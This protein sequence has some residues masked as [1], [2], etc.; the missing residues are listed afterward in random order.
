MPQET[1]TDKQRLAR[2]VF[3][4]VPKGHPD[5]TQGL[6]QRGY[7]GN[8]VRKDRFVAPGCSAR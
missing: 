1:P 8:V 6:G 4:F 3:F 7:A 5:G 2:H